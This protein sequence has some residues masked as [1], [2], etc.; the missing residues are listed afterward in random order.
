MC[1][2]VCL[3]LHT[4]AQTV[5][6]DDIFMVLDVG[7]EAI[8]FASW[9]L[10][11]RWSLVRLQNPVLLPDRKN[12]RTGRP[13]RHTRQV[14]SL[15]KEFSWKLHIATSSY[16]SRARTV[17][18]DLICKGTESRKW[19]FLAGRIALSMNWGSVYREEQNACMVWAS[20]SVSH[21]GKEQQ[22][23]S[24]QFKWR[25][26]PLFYLVLLF[27]SLNLWHLRLSTFS[28]SCHRI[29]KQ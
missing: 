7:S 6:N 26:K 14:F 9:S 1:V 16:I 11:V 24:S 12:G 15:F 8:I 19:S 5:L 25:A 18:H 27:A 3:C 2:F 21:Q 28:S 4:S 13:K 23:E 10:C 17:F 20:S 22:M 29:L